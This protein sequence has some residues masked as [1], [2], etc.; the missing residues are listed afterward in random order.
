[1]ENP[2]LQILH[3]RRKQARPRS[4]VKYSDGGAVRIVRS[5]LKLEI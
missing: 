3:H 4:A 2:R 5:D 1:M